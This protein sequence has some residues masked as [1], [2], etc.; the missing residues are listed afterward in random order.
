MYKL[1][2]SHRGSA[3]IIGLVI[4]ILI[5]IMTTSFLDK[6]L[7]LWKISGGIDKSAQAYTIATGLIEEQLMEWT[8]TKDAPWKIVPV[9]EPHT[10]TGRILN[11]ATGGTIIPSPWKWN[12]SFSW[13]WNMIGMSEPVQ[14]VIPETISGWSSVSFRFKVPNIPGASLSTGS[15]SNSWII[16]WIF[17]YSWAS[18]YASGETQIFQFDDIDGAAHFIWGFSW[19]TNTWANS[20]FQTFYNNFGSNC[21]NYQCTLKLSMIRPYISDLWQEFP[22]LEYQID[23]SSVAPSV[24]I[25]SQYMV[26]NS[27]S[28]IH[29]YLR[30]REIRIP[31][32]TTSTA[33][34]FAV[35][36]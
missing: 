10:Y 28:Y 35:L 26:I 1:H 15:V 25:P 12:S 3:L 6:V 5:T 17:G 14:I 34:D 29:G 13:D 8:M 31:Q 36:Q 27:S 18:L 9:N 11:A 32:I 16:L 19:Q 20:D 24:V 2:Q 23:F 30:S 7:N 33:T 21:M 22:F 4:V